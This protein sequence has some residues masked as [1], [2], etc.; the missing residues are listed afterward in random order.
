MY[1]TILALLCGMGVQAAGAQALSAPG[2]PVTVAQN[3]AGA[4][5]PLNLSTPLVCDAVATYTVGPN[6]SN[7]NVLLKSVSV[8]GTNNTAAWNAMLAAAKNKAR[9]NLVGLSL[10]GNPQ[11]GLQ[12]TIRLPNNCSFVIRDTA[13]LPTGLRIDGNHANMFLIGG[14]TAIKDMGINANHFAGQ[15]DTD[16]ED[17]KITWAGP[18]WDDATPASPCLYFSGGDA[19]TL[20]D[21]TVTN[22]TIALAIGGYEYFHLSNVILAHNRVGRYYTTGP[23]DVYGLP[24]TPWSVSQGGNGTTYTSGAPYPGG[25]PTIDATCLDC[26]ERE[27]YI[28][29]WFDGA[30][31]LS[32]FGGTASYASVLPF[33]FGGPLPPWIAAVTL[34]APL[35]GKAVACTANAAIPLTA[36]DKSGGAGAEILYDTNAAGTGGT[37]RKLYAG[38][39]Y[40]AATT[41]ITAPSS[42]ARSCSN[43]PV[44]KA[45]VRNMNNWGMYTGAPVVATSQILIMGKNVEALSSGNT[46]G[47]E[48]GLI[49]YGGTQS[50]QI[51][52]AY[53]QFA[54]DSAV[55]HIARFDG[56]GNKFR[57]NWGMNVSTDSWDGTKCPLLAGVAGAFVLHAPESDESNV[58]VCD[59]TASTASG[60]VYLSPSAVG[61]SLFGNPVYS[62]QAVPTVT[63]Y[64]GSSVP[65]FT[66]PFQATGRPGVP[67]APDSPGI[68]GST[69][70]P[71]FASCIGI[72]RWSG[73]PY[74]IPVT[75][76]NRV[77]LATASCTNDTT[78]SVTFYQSATTFGAEQWTLATLALGSVTAGGTAGFTGS[79]PSGKSLTVKGGIVV[80]CN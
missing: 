45:R 22:C 79:C 67:P 14:G 80:G 60:K 16:I 18:P 37:L 40:A 74:G 24:A 57:D 11:S 53:N 65:S 13:N 56:R 28:N 30:A 59:L 76:Q 52:F 27:N 36:A 63:S 70:L 68:P 31:G 61:G 62:Q 44:F 3:E 73:L 17:L 51:T 55:P 46:G 19:L 34:A 12:N 6:S 71:N 50:G 33:L 10:E 1:K 26:K 75:P 20:R 15:S 4:I 2:G 38:S 7:T 23:H 41:T 39:G 29:E 54:T 43:P 35:N 78:A 72:W 42:G 48:S 8:T 5:S 69:G 32:E 49:A 66:I 77:Y 64:N 47:P 25:G 9:P 21:I 58:P